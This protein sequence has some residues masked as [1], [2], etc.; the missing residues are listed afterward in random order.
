[1]SLPLGAPVPLDAIDRQRRWEV[2]G[3]NRAI[4]RWRE[5]ESDRSLDQR[6]AGRSVLRDV[7]PRLI[8]RLKAQQAEAVESIANAGRG[9]PTI[10]WWYVNLLPAPELAVTVAVS[11]LS[12][13]TGFSLR[14]EMKYP[15]VRLVAA[16]VNVA[17]AVKLQAEFGQWV[18]GERARAAEAKARDTA[19]TNLYEALRRNAKAI[20]TRAVK[21]WWKRIGRMRDEQ[22]PYEDRVQFGSALLTWLVESGGGWFELVLVPRPGGKTQRVLRLTDLARRAMDDITERAESA[23]A[24]VLPMLCPPSPWKEAA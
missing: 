3:V 22:W 7:V 1:M 5:I 8:Q 16:S 12:A 13:L 21:T 20:D 17:A 9:K 10:W 14:D 18:E 2:E 19:Y 15:G 6:V 24:Y 23:Q 11:A 4:R